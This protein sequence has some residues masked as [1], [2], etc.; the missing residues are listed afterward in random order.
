M[1]IFKQFKKG[2][3]Q[4][5]ESGKE[6]RDEMGNLAFIPLFPYCNREVLQPLFFEPEDNDGFIHFALAVCPH[7]KKVIG[8]GGTRT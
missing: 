8:A 6:G 3:E 2:L 1:K 7:C 5:V 4:M